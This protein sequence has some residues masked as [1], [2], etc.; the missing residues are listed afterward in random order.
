MNAFQHIARCVDLTQD[1]IQS[2]IDTRELTRELLEHLAS[3]SAP[4]TGVVKVLHVFAAILRE[5][6]EWLEGELRVELMPA[7]EST[8]LEVMCHLGAG[9]RER[10]FP[11][12]VLQAPLDELLRGIEVAPREIDPLVRS[13]TGDRV[14]LAVAGPMSMFPPSVAIGD[15]S[16]YAKGR[17]QAQ[18]PAQA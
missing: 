17:A 18:A 14:V 13:R 12:L 9:M 6:C 11:P 4:G 5:Q 7:A 8:L 16:I 15:D 3:V 1:D 10:V 2:A